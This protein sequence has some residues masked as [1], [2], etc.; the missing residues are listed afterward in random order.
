MDAPLGRVAVP[1]VSGS[2]RISDEEEVTKLRKARQAARESRTDDAW[3]VVG[4]LVERC[5]HLGIP[6]EEWLA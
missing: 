5:R 4:A 6:E 2:W 3:I 1:A